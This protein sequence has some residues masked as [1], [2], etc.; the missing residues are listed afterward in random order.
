MFFYLDS[1]L[2][3]QLEFGTK[4]SKEE[5]N[6]GNI[7]ATFDSSLSS[8]HENDASAFF[9]SNMHF[10]PS[11]SL[12]FWQDDAKMQQ[13]E[14]GRDDEDEWFCHKVDIQMPSFYTRP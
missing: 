7:E 4:S 11:Q 2:E 8:L 5:G 12:G 6:N 10:Y 3:S 9:S 13:A 1:Q 14:S